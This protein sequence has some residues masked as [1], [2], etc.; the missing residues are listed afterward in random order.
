MGVSQIKCTHGDGLT[1]EEERKE[2]TE[3][4]VPRV[5]PLRMAAVYIIAPVIIMDTFLL[6][7]STTIRADEIGA[8]FLVGLIIPAYT[9]MN[10][11]TAPLW[12]WMADKY[13]RRP[14]LIIGSFFTVPACV[15]F[16]FATEPWHLIAASLIRGIGGSADVPITRAIAADLA[17][18]KV[19]GERMGAFTMAMY[20]APLIGIS[21]YGPLY[22]MDWRLPF[23]AAAF[24]EFLDFLLVLFAIPETLVKKG[25]PKSVEETKPYRMERIKRGAREWY[26]ILK[27]R[28]VAL[29]I[30]STLVGA[31]VGRGISTLAYPLY[32]R[33]F[34][35]TPTQLG[36]VY[37]VGMVSHQAGG[38]RTKSEGSFR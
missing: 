34:G 27:R 11:L 28:G 4:E 20:A 38:F 31:F 24:T 35:L 15:F 6:L 12:G 5:H 17:P 23:L 32:T 8:G 19:L 13:G 33:K 37:V 25:R 21:I 30:F 18:R 2:E 7:F 1:S 14:P 9:G 22:E 16:A 3:E 10:V 29:V 36:I 26:V